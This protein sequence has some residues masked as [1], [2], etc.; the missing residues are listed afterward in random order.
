MNDTPDML[1]GTKFD[2]DV[3]EQADLSIYVEHG[4]SGDAELFA[5]KYGGI[6]VYSHTEKQ[7]FLKE[8][9]YYIKDEKGKIVKFVKNIAEMYFASATAAKQGSESQKVFSRRAVDL[10]SKHRIENVLWHAQSN[11]A[12]GMVTNE[13]SDDP[14]TLPVANGIIDLRT[15]ELRHAKPGEYI[16]EHSDVEWKGLDAPCPLWDK[17]IL[18][19]HGGDVVM[20]EFMQRVFGYTISGN[21]DEKAFFI[22]Y[23]EKGNNGKSTVNETIANV[24]GEHFCEPVPANVLMSATKSGNAHGATPFLMILKGKRFAW[25]GENDA[26]ARVNVG[27]I[28]LATGMDRVTGRE[29]YGDPENFSA[30]HKLFLM[31]NH[32][33]H[34]PADDNAMWNRVIPI[35]YAQSFAEQPTEKQLPSD[36][37]LGRKLKAE[38]SG[39][40]AWLVRGCMEWQKIGLKVPEAVK[41]DKSAYRESEDDLFIFLRDFCTIGVDE[42]D[43]LSNI[44]SAYSKDCMEANKHPMQ[45]EAFGRQMT[46]RFGPSV[47]KRSKDTGK[48]ERF[49]DGISLSE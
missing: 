4:E 13:W 22:Q 6:V 48:L 9:D 26:G 25:A 27:M 30:T 39:I 20:V 41:Q 35:E 10:L 17:T 43:T 36:K 32:K 40:L 45:R 49:Y 34:I 46:S 12:I 8:G 24:I 37:D 19:I 42:R 28:K 14:M 18:R 23:G 5:D 2:K 44:Y 11:N 33:P 1:T 16:R 38:Y 15:G 3:E 29:N 7:W 21:V 31:T 47:P